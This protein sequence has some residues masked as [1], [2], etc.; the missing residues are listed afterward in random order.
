MA[1]QLKITLKI[2]N[3]VAFRVATVFSLIFILLLSTAY[4]TSLHTLKL[5]L[6]DRI[7]TEILHE[8]N[9]LEQAL[10]NE[11]LNGLKNAIDIEV[12][13]SGADVLLIKVYDQELKEVASSNMKN[14]HYSNNEGLAEIANE[15]IAK[16]VVYQS[17]QS[18]ISPFQARL[19]SK[20]IYKDGYIIQFGLVMK[21][22]RLLIERFGRIFKGLIF[23]ILVSG[24]FMG[25]VVSFTAMAGVRRVAKTAVMVGKK[26]LHYRVYAGNAG[27]EITELANAFND[28]LNR[29]EVLME[30]I[31]DV[32]NNVAH[33]LRTPITRIQTVAEVTLRGEQS[34]TELK[35]GYGVIVDEC[36]NL[37]KI[38]NMIL[39]IAEAEVVAKS[40]E[41]HKIDVMSVTKKSYE[42]YLPV[43]QDKNIGM[44]LEK[45][46]TPIYVYGNS[47]KLQRII[48][49]LLDNAIKYTEQ[50]ECI[51][52]KIEQDDTKVIVSV[53]DYGIGIDERY[54]GRIFEKFYRVE[55]SRSS[56]GSGL[57]LTWS[58]SIAALFGWSISV[59]ST[60]GQGSQFSLHMPKTEY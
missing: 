48:S 38:I 58:K 27:Q 37:K 34:V 47:L 3:T 55:S 45:C 26:G 12:A 21:K 51:L 20:L 52:I 14:W 57:G 43:A 53:K 19:I 40:T 16:Q 15:S 24:I 35:E 36:N 29:I 1:T 28:M 50:D 59:T 7:D 56:E 44:T 5:N 46:D 23:L 17:I 41:V 39:E 10:A 30:E 22:D 60:L 49:N 54:L 11:G 8:I 4:Y 6:L 32:T 9:E 42:L 18:P 25:F 33:D 31:K 2:F 13:Q